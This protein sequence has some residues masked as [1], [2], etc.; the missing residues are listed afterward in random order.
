M[1]SRFRHPK[2]DEG[3]DES[4]Y[5]DLPRRSAFSARRALTNFRTSAAGKGLPD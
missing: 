2:I 4:H 5:F 3:T 1:D